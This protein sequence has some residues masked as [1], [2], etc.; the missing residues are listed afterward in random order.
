MGNEIT[1]EYSPGE[2]GLLCSGEHGNRLK[3]GSGE[4][5]RRV[6]VRVTIRS[7]QHITRV[8]SKIMVMLGDTPCEPT[9]ARRLEESFVQAIRVMVIRA[10]AKT[11]RA[12]RL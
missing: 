4:R 10:T 9:V 3:Y 5:E 8:N 12:V 7:Y 11:G 2:P 6:A 1:R